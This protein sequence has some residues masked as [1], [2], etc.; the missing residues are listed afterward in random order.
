MGV[1]QS[2]ALNEVFERV[3]VVVIGLGVGKNNVSC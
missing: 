1:F 3:I 2:L